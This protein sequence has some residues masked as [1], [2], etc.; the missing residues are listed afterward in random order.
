MAHN[1]IIQFEHVRTAKV[2]EFSHRSRWRKRVGLIQITW[3]FGIGVRIGIKT[4]TIVELVKLRKD[5]M[6]NNGLKDGISPHF[7]S[8]VDLPRA[9]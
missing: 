7:D 6:I 1:L 4:L 8:R 2:K 3:I 9:I 5:E